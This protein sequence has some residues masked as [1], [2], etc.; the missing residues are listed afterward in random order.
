ME[1]EYKEVDFH[2]YCETCEYKDIDDA[3]DPCNDCLS[4]PM[5]LHSRKPVCYKESRNAAKK[6]EDD[7]D[8]KTENKEKL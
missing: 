7:N 1:Y 3:K 8:T 2:T 4:E 5:N 6:G